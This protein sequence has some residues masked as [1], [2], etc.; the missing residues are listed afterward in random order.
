MKRAIGGLS[1]GALLAGHSAAGSESADP[2]EPHRWHMPRRGA[3]DL[4]QEAAGPVHAEWNRLG[5][6]VNEGKSQLGDWGVK[7]DA[8]LTVFDQGGVVDELFWKQVALGGKLLV[9]AG[10]IDLLDHFDSNRAPNDGY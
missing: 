7:F 6:L 8:D 9:L 5:Q 1:V 3:R 10:K 2:T 4:A